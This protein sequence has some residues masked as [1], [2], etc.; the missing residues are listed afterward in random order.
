WLGAGNLSFTQAPDIDLNTH[1]NAY[2][3][4]IQDLN[5]DGQKDLVFTSPDRTIVYLGVGNGTFP[6]RRVYVDGG[7]GSAFAAD[8]DSDNWLD[9]VS[10]Q[11]IQFAVAGSG[12]FSVLLNQ[13]NGFFKSAPAFETAYDNV[14]IAVGDLN[15]DG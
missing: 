8:V 5:Q 1:D 4:L 12:A 14:D 10:N 9:I 7:G 6:Q 11:S 3:S 2:L 13:R 15:S